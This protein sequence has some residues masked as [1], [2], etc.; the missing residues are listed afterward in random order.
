MD[1]CNAVNAASVR[2]DDGAGDKVSIKDAL[3]IAQFLVKARD[4][5]F[6]TR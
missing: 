4:T 6:N 3:F 1:H 5:S 2:Q